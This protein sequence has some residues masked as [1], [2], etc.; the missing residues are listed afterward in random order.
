MAPR[1]DLILIA[2]D[3]PDL[4]R[5][6]EVNLRF[7]GFEVAVATD[8]EQALVKALEFGPDLVLLDVSMPRLNGLE[9]CQRLRGDI[10]TKNM[11]VIMLTAKALTADRVVGLTAGADDYIIKPFDPIELVARV[12][13]T[14]T[15]SHELRAVNPLT[16]LP[17]NVQVHSALSER[18]AS[19]RR[20]ALLYIDLDNFKAFN[21]HN[22]FL[23][24]D[25]AIKLV[26]TCI[27]ETVAGRAGS[28]TFVGHIGG[29]DFVAIT[30]ADEAEDVAQGII[31]RWDAQVEGFYDAEDRA[32]GYIEITD[33]RNHM[34]HVPLI[35]VSIGIAT[36]AHR[37]LDSHWRASEIATEMKNF[38]KRRNESTYAIDRRLTDGPKTVHLA[39][40]ATADRT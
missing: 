15:R 33:R 26:A 3:D 20:F 30:A 17:G 28:D 34:H 2:D 31:D 14:L 29:D 8:G 21:D 1:P 32:R 19:G 11:S 12:K 35:S 6:V 40:P 37:E 24:G 9:V 22:G 18:I 23:R 13:T 39:P 36:N 16:Q 25:E 4:V 38:A 7:E 27:T 5:F 10:R